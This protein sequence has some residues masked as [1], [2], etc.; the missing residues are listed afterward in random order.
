VN[1]QNSGYVRLRYT[2]TGALAA[3]VA[4]GAIAAAIALAASPHARPAPQPNAS[5]QPFL[6][7]IQRLVDNDTI[8]ASEGQVVDREIVAG[9]VD[10]DSLTASGF[11]QTQ[12]QA[13]QQA[14]TSTKR[15]IAQNAH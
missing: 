11:T 13:V 4:V 12:L 2:A 15:A 14:L 10:T 9:K 8:T 5:Q 7:D 1:D 6:S 3:L